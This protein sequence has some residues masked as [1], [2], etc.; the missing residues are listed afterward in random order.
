M[1]PERVGY[2][3]KGTSYFVKV[4]SIRAGRKAYGLQLDDNIILKEAYYEEAKRF[5]IEEPSC[6]VGYIVCLYNGY[7]KGIYVQIT[8]KNQKVRKIILPLKMFKK[9]EKRKLTL[10]F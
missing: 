10:S 1:I 7:D 3:D 9:A 2:S 6:F 5:G 4:K 8:V